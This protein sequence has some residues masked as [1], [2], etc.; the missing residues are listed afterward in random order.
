MQEW[1]VGRSKERSCGSPMEETV[2][3]TSRQPCSPPGARQPIA[4]R[5]WSQVVR[6]PTR[7]FRWVTSK[8]SD[9]E[10]AL[11]ERRFNDV[12]VFSDTEIQPSIQRWQHALVGKFLGRCLSVD[13]V[14]GEMRDRW[15]IT[16]DF[17]VSAL[18]EGFFLFVFST[19]EE[20]ARVLEKGPG[21][22][23]DSF[24][25]WNLGIQGLDPLLMP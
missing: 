11:L 22:W 3:P 9:P 25:P 20:K 21:H 14:D 8:A 12:L 6:G 2:A 16:G 5:T 1:E 10:I 7:R 13:F 23:L 19:K 24:S 18:S 15:S 17:S 4:A